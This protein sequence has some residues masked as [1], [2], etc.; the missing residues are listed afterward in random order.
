MTTLY[1]IDEH[2][3]LLEIWRELDLRSIQL[4]H[5]D[6][7]CDMRG[8][9]V[10]RDRHQATW[11]GEQPYGLD[12]GN[13][14]SHAVLENRVDDVNWVH[15][16]PGGRVYDLS[17]VIFERDFS[18][19][20]PWKRPRIETLRDGFKCRVTRIE[21]WS[22]PNSNRWLDIDWDTFSCREIPRK[23][24]EGRVSRFLEQLRNQP[25]NAPEFITICLSAQYSHPMKAEFDSFVQS[26]ADIYNAKIVFRP[27][28]GEK[29]R[30]V[31]T[32]QAKGIKY[33]LKDVWLRLKKTLRRLGI[34]F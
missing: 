13:F 2:E 14:I 6:F 3:Q 9:Y 25:G 11:V 20:I 8:M 16:V 4:D 30:S 22:G 27:F 21:K 18:F 31:S 29:H 15:D 32:N 12:E 34:Y 7:H 1:V 17:G 24:V 5:V 28:E 33:L 10:D 26:V 19:L 23:S